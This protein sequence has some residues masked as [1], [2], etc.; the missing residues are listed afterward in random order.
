MTTMI[1]EVYEAFKAAGVPDDKAAAAAEAIES[2]R[3]EEGLRGIEKE[4]AELKTDMRLLK[5]MVGF[6]LA[7]STAILIKLLI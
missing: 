4:I 7:L 3:E 6:N 2:I 1:R 5:W